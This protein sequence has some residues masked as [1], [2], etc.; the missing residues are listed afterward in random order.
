MKNINRKRPVNVSQI[1]RVFVLV[2]PDTG[3]MNILTALPGED[4]AVWTAYFRSWTDALKSLH[5]TTD[6]VVF[7]ISEVCL[8]DITFVRGGLYDRLLQCIQNGR[9]V[10]AARLTRQIVRHLRANGA[11]Q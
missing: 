5:F 1:A 9:E 8:I 7:V 6:V 10:D 2:S 11:I 4:V 3:D